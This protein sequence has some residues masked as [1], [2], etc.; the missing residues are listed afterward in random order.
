VYH[1]SVDPRDGTFLAAANSQL[2]G[3]TV[4]RSVDGG[5]SRTR[6][7]RIGLLACLF[8]GVREVRLVGI[9]AGG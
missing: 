5:A 3:P 4:R 2:S 7:Q 1:A 6:C 9:I 8:A